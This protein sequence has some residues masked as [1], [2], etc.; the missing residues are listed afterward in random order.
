MR[1]LFGCAY[2]GSHERRF[3]LTKDI[4]ISSLVLGTMF[5]PVL[6][7]VVIASLIGHYISTAL[8][9]AQGNLIHPQIL[10]VR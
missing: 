5:A 9:P 1:N 3:S 6:P 8:F 7:S 10:N 2:K 4:F